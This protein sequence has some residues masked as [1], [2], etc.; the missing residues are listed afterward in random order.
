MEKVG[1]V[2]VGSAQRRDRP[3]SYPHPRA[4]TKDARVMSAP[5]TQVHNREEVWSEADKWKS[6]CS[7]ETLQQA[8]ERVNVKAG[9]Q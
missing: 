1:K 7:E 2:K 6:L 3:L 5:D 9:V 8:R 4:L